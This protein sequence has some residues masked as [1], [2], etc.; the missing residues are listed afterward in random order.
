MRVNVICRNFAKDRVLPRFAR[1]LRDGCGWSL[2]TAP[3]PGADAYYLMGYFEMQMFGPGQWPPSVP[4]ASL[5]THR[6]ERDDKKAAL[7]DR[8]AS[9]VGLR[10]AMC[11]LYGDPLGSLGPTIVPPLP[12]ERDRFVPAKRHRNAR[13]VIGVS[14]YTYGTGRKGEAMIAEAVRALGDRVA[15][16]ASGRGWPVPVP[17]RS[18]SWSDMP[19]FYQS[20]DVL[21]CPST[22]E[23]GPMPVLEALSCGVQVVV[24]RGVGI[25]DELPGDALGIHRYARGDTAAM[26]AAVRMAIMTDESS[27]EELRAVTEPYTVAAWCAENGRGVEEVLG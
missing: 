23:G 2:T 21:V 25:L 3:E 9:E 4:T 6:E 24:P 22:V 10:V 15:W 19:S 27:Q 1:Y 11:Q 13:P 16:S 14:G 26:V 7:Y 5:F 12:V 17:T 18:Y 20:L 8:I